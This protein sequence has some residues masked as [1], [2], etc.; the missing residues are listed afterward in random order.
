MKISHLS[1]SLN[2]REWGITPI[3]RRAIFSIHPNPKHILVILIN[4]RTHTL[5]THIKVRRVHL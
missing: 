5:R 4:P 2:L 1:E 3:N